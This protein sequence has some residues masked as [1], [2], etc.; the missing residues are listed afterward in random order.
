[1]S[2][3]EFDSITLRELYLRI[4]GHKEYQEEQEYNRLY[5]LRWQTARLINI[6]ATREQ[7]LIKPKDLF[8]LK[9]EEEPTPHATIPDDERRQEIREIKKKWKGFKER[10]ATPEE[11]ENLLPLKENS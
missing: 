10:I 8:T 4:A 9:Y 5:W 2:V 3:K 1:M 11:L 7:D 6:H